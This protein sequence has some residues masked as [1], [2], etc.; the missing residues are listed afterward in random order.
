MKR[1]YKTIA[2]LFALDICLLILSGIPAFK[3]ANHGAKDVIGGIGWFGFLLTTLV[4]VVLA[5]TALVQR[6]RLA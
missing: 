5:I 3:N 1:I 6:R 2:A 4:L